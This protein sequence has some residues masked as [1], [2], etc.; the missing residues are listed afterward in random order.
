MPYTAVHP[1]AQFC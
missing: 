1:T